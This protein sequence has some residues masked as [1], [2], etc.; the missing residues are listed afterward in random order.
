MKEFTT[1]MWTMI[2]ITMA[3]ALALIGMVVSIPAKLLADFGAG[4]CKLADKIISNYHVD[5]KQ[6]MSEIVDMDV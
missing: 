5:G 2:K 6:I 3:Y 4:C 1:G